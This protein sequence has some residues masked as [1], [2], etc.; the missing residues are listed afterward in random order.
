MPFSL[1]GR[2]SSAA[3]AEAGGL[4]GGEI[5]EKVGPTPLPPGGDLL[6]LDLVPL[7]FSAARSSIEWLVSRLKLDVSRFRG[8]LRLPSAPISPIEDKKDL[9]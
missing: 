1:D 9:Q 2:R 6:M 3:E 5:D 7:R 4:E 8:L